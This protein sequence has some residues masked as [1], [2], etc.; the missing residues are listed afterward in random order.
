MNFLHV[1]IYMILLQV[2]D[3]TI[4]TAETARQQFFL[5]L[6]MTH[7]IPLL[8]IGPTGTGKSAITG[9]YLLALPKEL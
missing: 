4:P 3:L 5:N 6:Y 1:I 9:S 2:S 8:V 7:S